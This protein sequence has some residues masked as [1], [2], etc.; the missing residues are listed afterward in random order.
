M[1]ITVNHIRGAGYCVV[2]LKQ[3]CHANNIDFKRLVREGIP[4]EE[5]LKMNDE[6]VNDVVERAHGRK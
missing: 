4:E 1:L 6:M 5:L 2:G 3:F